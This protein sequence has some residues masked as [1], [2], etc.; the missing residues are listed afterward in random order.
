MIVLVLLPLPGTY[1]AYSATSTS[2]G[3]IG[4]KVYFAIESKAQLGSKQLYAF[5]IPKE[6]IY[7]MA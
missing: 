3:Q 7:S 6:L 1:A 5:F 2:L 4:T